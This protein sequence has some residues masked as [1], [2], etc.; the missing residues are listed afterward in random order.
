MPTQKPQSQVFRPALPPM[1]PHLTKH[2]RCSDCNATAVV[3][4]GGEL[5]V[6][7]HCFC[8]LWH[9][10]WG[11]EERRVKAE[12]AAINKAANAEMKRLRQEAHDKRRAHLETRHLFAED[13]IASSPVL[14]TP[15][16]GTSDDISIQPSEKP[17]AGHD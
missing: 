7:P 8:L 17:E 14:G 9:R 13:L 11:A 6:C 16:M 10:D 4:G 1:A 15:T 12:Q 5:K 2:G 3:A